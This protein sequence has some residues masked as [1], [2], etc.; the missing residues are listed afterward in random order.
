MPEIAI[1]KPV[2]STAHPPSN[3]G[4]DQ[5][6]WCE[7]AVCTAPTPMK[8]LPMAASIPPMASG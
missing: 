6:F 4:L 8:A 3:Q 1:R 5:T 7:P 2:V